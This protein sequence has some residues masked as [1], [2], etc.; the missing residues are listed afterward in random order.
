MAS[1]EA[2]PGLVKRERGEEMN[3]SKIKKQARKLRKA[4]KAGARMPEKSISKIRWDIGHGKI[5][6]T[7]GKLDYRVHQILDCVADKIAQGHWFGQVLGLRNSA[8][9]K[10]PDRYIVVIESSE[11]KNFIADQKLNSKYICEIFKRVPDIVL[12]G[13]TKIPF[14]LANNKWL[15]VNFYKDNICGVAIAW[16]FKE[17]RQYRSDRTL[18]GRG[19]GKE[20]PVFVFLFSNPYGL[21]FFRNAMRREGAQIQDPRLYHLSPEAQ[22]LFQAVRWKTDLIATNTEQA[23]KMMSLT[24]PVAR[25]NLYKRV[26]LIRKCLKILYENEFINQPTEH[27]KTIEKKAWVFYVRKRKLIKFGDNNN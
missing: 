16:E 25:T 7:S 5:K 6:V 1:Q 18:R 17:F 23:S 12:E 21:A 2:T 22:E 8:I 27:G 15:D 26:N 14:C 24:W 11:F 3:N 19:A 4:L 20:E 9:T 13:Y 10:E